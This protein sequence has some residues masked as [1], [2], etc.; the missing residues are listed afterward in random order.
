MIFS[1]HNIRLD[2][3]IRTL[4]DDHPPMET[5]PWFVSARRVLDTVFPGD[6]HRCRIADLGCLEGGFSVEFA[7]LG[8][9][10]LGGDVREGNIAACNYVKSH[11]DLPELEFT[12]DDVWNIASHG[13]FDA[14]FC[15]GLLYHLDR[16]RQFLELLARVT[17]RLLI[18]QTH[19]ST[20]QPNA[21]HGLSEIAEH[22]DALGRW[23]TEFPDDAAFSKRETKVW[24]SWDNR[25][26]FWMKRQFLIQA[27]KDAGFD[28][29]MEQY[30][31]PGPDIEG[32]MSFGYYKEDERGTFIGIKTAVD[33]DA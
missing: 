29:V 26:S 11:V 16:P 31:S 14:T 12:R 21:K 13:S 33:A 4:S 2:S 1:A 7:R 24:A 20:E 19:F 17:R 8:F 18:V 5:H 28:L 30:D 27:I 10:V 23:Y 32:S 15:C 25:R 6:K 3:G 9:Q 22:E